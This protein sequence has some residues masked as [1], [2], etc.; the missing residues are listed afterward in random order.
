MY[1]LK[2]LLKKYK[3]NTLF[4]DN[5]IISLTCYLNL[6]NK[7]KNKI[8]PYKLNFKDSLLLLPLSISKLIEAFNINTKKLPFPYKFINKNNLNYIGNIPSYFEFFDEFDLK[9]YELYLNLSSKYNDK[10]K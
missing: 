9:K 8:K 10:I 3:I 5:K 6:K 7:D 1:L 2:V 4:K